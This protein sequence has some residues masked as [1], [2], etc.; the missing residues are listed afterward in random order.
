MNYKVA[1]YA[2]FQRDWPEALRLYEEAYHI[3]QEVWY[4]ND[5]SLFF[6]S[7]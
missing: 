1:V 7:L 4:A 6:H 3:V 2:E 5:V